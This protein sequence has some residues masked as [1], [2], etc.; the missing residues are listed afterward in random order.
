MSAILSDQL[1][2]WGIEDNI[3]IYTDGS[4]GFALELTPLDVSCADDYIA[5][6]IH[7]DL[8]KFLNSLP[9]GVDLQFIQEITEGNNQ[10]I[11]ENERLCHLS[12]SELIKKL[13]LKRVNDLR[14]YDEQ[15]LIPTHKLKL[16]IRKPLSKSLITKKSVFSSEKRFPQI[17]EKNLQIEVKALKKLQGEIYQ[18]LQNMRL[19]VKTIETEKIVSDVYDLWNPIRSLKQNIKM[20]SYDPS[21][22]REAITFTDSVINEAGFSLG[23]MKHKVIS[24]KVLPGQT[25]S[26]MVSCLRQLPFDSKLFLSVHVPDQQKEIENLQTQRR[27]AFS[28]VYGKQT[29]VSDLE[30]EAK[31]QDL[32]ELL[33][34]LVTSGEKVF[35]FGLNVLLRSE[36]ED[37]LEDQVSQTLMLIRDLDGAE[38]LEETIAS[39]DIFKDF[40]FPNARVKERTK[41]IKT[42][43]LADMLPVYGPWTGHNE[44]KVI[45]RSRMGNIFKFNPFSSELTNPNQIISGSSGSGKSFLTNLLLIQMLKENPQIFIVDIGGSY[46]KVC[47]NLSGQYIPLGLDTDI[48]INPF[49]LGQGETNPSND[50]IKFL[51]ALIES[52]TKE[53]A[54]TGLKKLE[55]SEIEQAI[56]EIY[57]ENK[58][59]T[60]SQLKDK[61]LKHNEPSLNKIGKILKSWCGNTPYGRFLDSQTNVDIH[62]DTVCFDLKGLELYPDLQSSC[63]LMIS[64]LVVRKSQSDKSRM[65]YLVFDECW[66]LLQGE[67][68][69]FIG[70]IFRTC[71]KY[72]MSC[73]AISQ[74]IDDFA[75]SSA[76][77]AIMSNSSI[78]WLLIQRGSDK[79]RLKEV[80][81]LNDNEINLISTLSQVSGSYSEAFLMCENKRSVV[82]I[83]CTPYEYWLATTAPKDITLMEEELKKDP[84]QS[85]MELIFKLA[86]LS[87]QGA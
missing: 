21:D 49:D 39:F 71:R 34:Q 4:I 37:V 72:F 55:R 78:K 51:L 67:G 27:L 35:H 22:L 11:N 14:H 68:A 15:G 5:N 75:R 24:L 50:K 8:C 6:Q 79:E 31:F 17:S 83:E 23:K 43:N 86:Q 58:I 57:D 38:G 85:Q 81:E 29:G 19:T 66:S 82:V 47:D 7:D 63:L 20:E 33:A 59:P 54:D 28:M 10:I 42:S 70:S 76:S 1:Q 16:I 18:Q 60:L 12:N 48:S 56:L 25:F 40:S 46:K 87:P 62:K 52:M 64:D 80:L 41:R 53:E 84:T 36:S 69:N 61:L 30:S 44:P 32:E 26:T 45:L 77:S 65:K 2:V 74:N 13:N 73:I 3:I 9:S